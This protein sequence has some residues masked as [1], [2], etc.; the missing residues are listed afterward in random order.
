MTEVERIADQLQRSMEG[1]AWHGPALL[2]VLEGVTAEEAARSA[3]T[4]LRLSGLSSS[5]RTS[6]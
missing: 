4:V 3:S 6:V 1:N 5:A 2:E